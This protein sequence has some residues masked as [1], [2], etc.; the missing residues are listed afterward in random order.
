MLK[1]SNFTK[2]F[3]VHI[4]VSDY[5]IGG[6]LMQDGHPIAFESKIP[7][8]AQLQWPTH[9]KNV[10]HDVLPQNLVTLSRDA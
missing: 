10:C 1:F 5:T 6:V 9:E 4:D 7:Y 2:L 8:G 3:K